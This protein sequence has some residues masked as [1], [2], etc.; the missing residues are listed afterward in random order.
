[1]APCQNHSLQ[2]DALASCVFEDLAQ[3]VLPEQAEIRCSQPFEESRTKTYCPGEL[4]RKCLAH[5]TIS[6]PDVHQDCRSECSTVETESLLM[7]RLSPQLSPRESS[8]EGSRQIVLSKH[9]DFDNIHCNAA[10]TNRVAPP[11]HDSVSECSTLEP[12]YMERLLSP[13]VSSHGFMERLLSPAASSE[14]NRLSPGASDTSIQQTD[15]C[16]EE[17]LQSWELDDDVKLPSIGSQ[18][19]SRGLCSPCGFV[20]S[21]NGCSGGTGCKFCHLC[22]AG[23]IERQR[24]MKRQLV[25]AKKQGRRIGGI[26]CEPVADTATAAANAA[27]AASAFAAAAR[28]GAKCPLLK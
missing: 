12:D 10:V 9:I 20:H 3:C 18:G 22:P 16:A 25:K 17:L 28:A 24:K 11:A 27:A 26:L 19:H 7:D 4:L 6:M 5:T 23:S 15:L 21:K 1:M 14:R 8:D 13:A 2:T